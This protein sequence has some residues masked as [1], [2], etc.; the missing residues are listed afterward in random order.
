MKFVS[1]GVQQASFVICSATM[2]LVLLLAVPSQAQLYTGSITGL[3]QDPS[4]AVVAN[5][6]VALT[7]N[8]K[9]LKYTAKTDSS[10][11]Y[12]LRALPPSTYAMRVEAAGFKSEEQ[13]GIVLV[14]NQN[15]TLNVPLQLGRT[16]ETVEVTGEAPVLATEDAV[17]GQNLDRKVI[18]DLPLVGRSVFDL[19]LLP[20][21]LRNPPAT[22]LGLIPWPTTSSPM[23]AAMHRPT[24]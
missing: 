13:R 18:N 4:G 22:R 17:T 12:V 23:A 7:D 5:A 19:A 1:N 2:C 10:G 24:S 6:S 20:L 11:R 15:L 8:D 16:S 21:E 3:V 9:G 14:V